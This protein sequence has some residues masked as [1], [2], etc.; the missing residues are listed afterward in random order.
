MGKIYNGP[1]N[2]N[3]IAHSISLD[4]SGNILVA[5]ESVG[6]N[7][8]RD[9]VLIKYNSQGEE[10]WTR[11]YSGSS[12][13]AEIPAKVVTD[14]AGNS[15]ITGNTWEAGTLSDVLTIKYN[16]DGAVQWIKQFNGPANG[17]EFADGMGIDQTG[18][19]YVCG[20]TIGAGTIN[21]FLI[22]KYSSDGNELWFRT[23]NGPVNGNDFPTSLTIDLSGNAIITGTSVGTGTSLDIATIKYS[24]SGDEIWQRRLTT[25]TINPEEAKSITSD[26]KG[27]IYIT[28]TSTGF[29]S[30][31]DYM[32]VKYSSTGDLMWAKNY[33]GPGTNNF[34][35]A[36]SVAAD[37]NGNV[38]V[39]G[40]SAGTGTMDDIVI[41]KYDSVGNETWVNRYNSPANRNDVANNISLDAFGNIIVSGFIT[42]AATA[43]DFSVI[44]FSL[45]TNVVSLASNAPAAFDLLQN[46]PNPFNPSTKIRFDVTPDERDDAQD[47]RLIVF[48]V[49]GKEVAALVNEKLSA[50]SYE[51]EF[52]ANDYPGGVYF[53]RLNAGEFTA[54][55]RMMLLK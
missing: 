22:I 32:T 50:G 3:D 24:P 17:N 18:N 35:E 49:L 41:V 46:Y 33:N 34:D 27:N 52:D 11:R 47:V 31:Y 13:S 6:N 26:N 10:Q 30:S 51:V 53:Y 43:M 44:K 14:N 20:S 4:N 36:R 28:G 37:N 21:D 40:L 23:Y 45:L 38:Y 19:I 48:D 29:S 55:K 9:Y 1:A 7:T 5:G 12:N 42:G 54:T 8:E 25:Q 2:G 39:T 16:S 15:I